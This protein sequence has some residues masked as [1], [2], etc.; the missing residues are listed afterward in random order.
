MNTAI[1]RAIKH[2]EETL[3]LKFE[4][5]YEKAHRI[6]LSW[7]SGGDGNKHLPMYT[8]VEI[9]EIKARIRKRAEVDVDYALSDLLA[10]KALAE[11]GEEP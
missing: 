4:H 8:D 1:E 3:L 6:M 2:V 10:N 11:D 9:K 5:D 7:T